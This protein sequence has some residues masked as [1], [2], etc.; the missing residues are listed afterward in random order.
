MGDNEQSCTPYYQ[1]KRQTHGEYFEDVKRHTSK[2]ITRAISENI[3]ESRRD[4]MLWFFG[5][6]GKS[7]PNNENYQF[8]QQDDNHPIELWE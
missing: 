6:E 4:W 8:W 1:Y 7:N 3:Q 2:I 5:R